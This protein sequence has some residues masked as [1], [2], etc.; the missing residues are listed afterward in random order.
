MA[1]LW[2]PGRGVLIED[3]GNKLLL[4]RFNHIV[5]MRRVME[6]G[7]WLFDDSLLLLRDIKKGENPRTVELYTAVYWVQVHDLPPGFFS[8]AVGLA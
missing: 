4:C 3:I 6:T 2:C 1:S 7:P 8:E 5:D